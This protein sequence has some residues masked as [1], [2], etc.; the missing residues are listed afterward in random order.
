MKYCFQFCTQKWNFCLHFKV[1]LHFTEQLLDFEKQ[2]LVKTTLDQKIFDFFSELFLFFMCQDYC[3]GNSAYILGPICQ[4]HCSMDQRINFAV[5]STGH[6]V[7]KNPVHI[8]FQ[9]FC[10]CGHLFGD[11]FFRLHIIVIKQGRKIPARQGIFRS[12]WLLAGF[13]SCF[14]ISLKGNLISN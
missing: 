9:I 2:V 6:I 3:F 7:W 1:E 12:Q 14:F 11:T 8:N 13:M 10:W 5:G 4:E